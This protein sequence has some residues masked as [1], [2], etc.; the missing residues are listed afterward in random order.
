MIKFIS[1]L[2]AVHDQH[3][4]VTTTPAGRFELL[5]RIT[6]D[7]FWDWDLLSGTIWW[8]EGFIKL[9]G[10]EEKQ[11]PIHPDLWKN[12][13]HPE[14][15]DRI[16]G[17][18]EKAVENGEPVWQEEYRFRKADGSYA[19][20]YD[21]G[22]TVIEA[23]KVVRMLGSMMDVTERVKRRNEKYESEE[24]MRLALDSAELGTWDFD[25][26]NNLLSLDSRCKQLY[27]F[28][29]N[30]TVFYKQLFTHTYS[31]DKA[32]VDRAVSSAH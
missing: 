4:S 28:S 32:R 11:V 25:I 29:Q 18:I 7:A 16:S 26:P 31:F 15:R 19:D 12:Y 30:D 8:N 21:R 2:S 13:I 9:F 1:Y 22:F 5:A 27:G 10:Y 14:D 17:S 23:G 24:R 6:H 20:V 3:S